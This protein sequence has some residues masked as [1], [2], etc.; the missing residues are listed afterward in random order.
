[1]ALGEKNEGAGELRTLHLLDSDQ[2]QGPQGIH[3]VMPG[4]M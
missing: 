1:M 4:R 2:L 3:K